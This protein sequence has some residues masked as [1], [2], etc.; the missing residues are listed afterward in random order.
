[1]R[2]LSYWPVKILALAAAVLLFVFNR[3]N[4]LEQRV[5][6]L[7]LEVI[8]PDGFV[9]ADRLQEHAVVTVRGESEGALRGAGP[10]EF[11]AYVD[12]T[13]F[14]KEGTFVVPVQYGRRGGARPSDAF[15]DRVEPTEV[16]VSLE[17]VAEKS[18]PVVANISGTPE[19][20]YSLNQY[21]ITPPI[22]R[23]RGP[24]SVVD[25]TTSVQTEEINLAGITGDYKTRIGLLA[26]SSLVSFVGTSRV[27]FYG[28]ISKVIVTREFDDVPIELEN[29]DPR[30]EWEVR[31]PFGRLV[32]K[33]PEV[34]L[35]EGEPPGLVVDLR[36]VG[37][38]GRQFHLEPIARV[39]DG[40]DVVD[41]EPK[42][43]T[44]ARQAKERQ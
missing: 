34:D 4:N 38:T 33:G 20:G 10:D 31:P 39:P 19:K 12:L 29:A 23:M 2:A 42:E 11:R 25:A 5:L 26:P 8:L 3:M 13:G 17:R 28:I 37:P 6:D 36:S 9:L 16:T 30:Y 24:R 27:E 43:V 44:V 21:T 15:V 35:D 18:L 1:M 7:P 40:V 14:H 22:V 32:V 41:F